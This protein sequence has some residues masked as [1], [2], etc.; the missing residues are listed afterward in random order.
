LKALRLF[1][2][3]GLL[4][5][6]ACASPPRAPAWTC[7]QRTMDS[8]ELSGVSDDRKHCLA[9]G[10][11]AIRCGSVS[12]FLAGWGKE[13]ADVF[14]P[15]DPSWHDLK[16][17]RAGRDCARAAPDETALPECCAKSGY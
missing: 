10:A 17:D 7:M 11:I 16:A 1:P 5:P 2:F 6:A 9:S 15:G 13:A 8:L 3:L 4:L 12:A 14:G